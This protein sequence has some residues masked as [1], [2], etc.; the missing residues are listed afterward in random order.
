M[1]RVADHE[2]GQRD[3]ANDISDLPLWR[4]VTA[5]DEA[6]R[7]MD[8]IV[9]LSRAAAE[10]DLLAKRTVGLRILFGDRAPL[11][12]PEGAKLIAE[13]AKDGDAPSA[14]LSA[15]L[16]GAGVYCVQ[17]WRA[18][19]DWLQY[20]AELGS[21]RARGALRLLCADTELGAHAETA[22]SPAELWRRLR[23]KVDIAAQLSPRPGHLL[24]GDPLIRV[25][26][27]FA[28]PQMC[29]WLIAQAQGRLARAQVYNPH[30]GGVEAASER[31]NRAA[32]FNLLDADLPQ[33]ILQAR[34]AATVGVPF[35]NL[36]P[37]A[38][39][40]Y[41]PGQMFED[42][43]DFVDPASPNYAEEIARNGQRRITFLLYLND[44][45]E[46]GE[47]AFPSLNLSHKGQAGQALSF[48]NVLPDGVGDTRTLHAGRPP[49]RG[50]KWV[51]S[52]FIRDRTV[53]P[54]I[55]PD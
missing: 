14:V 23:A 8:A 20:A 55:G 22:A 29:A 48:E 53:V 32:L 31:T 6:G 19:L 42:H 24:L 39:L 10:G 35:G 49:V 5:L 37:A 36:E 28:G 9:L 44:D 2:P 18:A 21:V 25:Y 52:Q 11:L 15:T 34:I 27:D 38:I 50:E 16:A 7:H 3:I 1:N 54:G 47:T 40:H 51:L 13:A 4:E 45:Y 33:I 12:G 43:Y 41:A 17:D 46:G 30:T 26:P